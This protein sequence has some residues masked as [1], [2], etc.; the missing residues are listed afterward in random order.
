MNVAMMFRMANDPTPRRKPFLRPKTSH[1]RSAM[2]WKLPYGQLFSVKE[3]KEPRGSRV[4]REL[5]QVSIYDAPTHWTSASETLNS[6][7]MVGIANETIKIPPAC[8]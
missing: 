2:S 1:S 4:R 7:W 6:F 5:T 8:G 3:R